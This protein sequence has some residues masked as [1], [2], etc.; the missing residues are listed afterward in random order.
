MHGS[1]QAIPISISTM[2]GLVTLAGPNS[3]PEGASPRCYDNDYGVGSTHTRD[4]LTSVYTYSGAGVGPAPGGAAVNE[5][6]AGV[7][8]TNP[9]NVL[10]DDGNYATAS[11]SAVVGVTEVVFTEHGKYSSSTPPTP[12]FSGAGSGASGTCIMTAEGGGYYFISSVTINSAGSYA[13]S[14]GVTVSF[15]GG[16]QV[17]SAVATVSTTVPTLFTDA[18]DITLFGFSVPSTSTP[19][20]FE[21][22]VKGFASDPSSTL[23]VQMLKAGVPVG[24]V[25]SLAMSGSAFTFGG[26]ND[27][28]GSTW[29]YSDLNSTTFGVR[30]ICVSSVTSNLSLG[31][32]TLKAFLLPT[33]T[34]FNF[35]AP[36]TDQNGTVK[37]ISLDASGNLWVEDVTN[38]PGVLTLAV[39]NIAPNSYAVGAQGEGVE[40]L[41]FNDGTAG[42][43]V[44]RQYTSQWIDRITQVG[45]G[46]APSLNARYSTPSPCA[47]TA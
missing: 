16:D 6:G 5:A 42:C 4:G 34:N 13:Y 41:A 31:Y 29:N 36:F 21:I 47:P 27:L 28:F 19:Q 14:G 20:G 43:D 18:L 10:L 22:D 8:W 46:A 30:I 45:P 7:D 40:Y 37:N 12:I 24:T 3:L 2:G 38:N 26:A 25:K 15:L 1:S 44:P 11:I 33:Q 9:A 17:I 39:S 35:I 23:T 32:V